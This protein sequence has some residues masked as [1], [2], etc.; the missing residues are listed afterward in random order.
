MLSRQAKLL[1][2]AHVRRLPTP[3]FSA[4]AAIAQYGGFCDD[5]ARPASGSEC[6]HCGGTGSR[7]RTHNRRAGRLAL[8]HYK[9]SHKAR[10][11]APSGAAEAA[12]LSMAEGRLLAQ[13]APLSQEFAP[14]GKNLP[15]K[16]SVICA[17]HQRMSVVG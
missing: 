4:R 15:L 5:R 1:L 10:P 6:T 7:H 9:L 2:D 16:E 14:K 12:Y 17:R 3:K 11:E 13:A 8:R